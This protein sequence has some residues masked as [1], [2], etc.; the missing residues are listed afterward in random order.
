M[1]HA[2]SPA[3][4]LLGCGVSL[5]LGMTCPAPLSLDTQ[6][7]KGLAALLVWVQTDDDKEQS[8]E[9][10]QKETNLVTNH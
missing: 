1:L 7:E 5:Y 10:M 2:E 8:F 4:G 9:G 3:F 6:P